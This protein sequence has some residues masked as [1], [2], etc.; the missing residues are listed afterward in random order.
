MLRRADIGGTGS[1]ERKAESGA[2]TEIR[3]TLCFEVWNYP[4]CRTQTCD[5]VWYLVAIFSCGLV[6]E[7]LQYVAAWIQDPGSK[8]GNVLIVVC[9]WNN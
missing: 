6:S 1:G 8:R 9:T 5:S 4:W 7:I 2:E 3:R